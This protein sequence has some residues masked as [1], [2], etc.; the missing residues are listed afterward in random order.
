[1]A[2]RMGAEE[3]KHL[4]DRHRGD[5]REQGDAQGREGVLALGHGHARDDP[6]TQAGDRELGGQLPLK[7]RT[8]KTGTRTGEHGWTGRLRRRYAQA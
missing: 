4:A 1:M 3:L 6:R 2:S 7:T 5:R 8:R